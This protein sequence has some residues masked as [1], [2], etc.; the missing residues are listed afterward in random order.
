MDTANP[1]PALISA[2]VRLADRIPSLQVVIDH[3]HKWKCLRHCPPALSYGPSSCESSGNDL[4]SM[5]R[6]S[7]VL[8]RVGTRVP[9][10]LSFYRAT[11][12]DLWEIFGPDRL[13]YGK[14]CLA[15]Q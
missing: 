5:S 7:E 2:V 13:M 8:R 6:W 15:E 12:D 10:D 11:M 1:D 3:L 9:D 4:K 14:Q